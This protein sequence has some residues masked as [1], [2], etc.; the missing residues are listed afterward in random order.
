MKATSIVGH[1]FCRVRSHPQRSGFMMRRTQAIAIALEGLH[2]L[3]I[4]ENRRDLRHSRIHYGPKIVVTLSRR[5]RDECPANAILIVS[6]I[7]FD[8]TR[9]RG[10]IVEVGGRHFAYAADR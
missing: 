1:A 4:G 3:T 2:R 5:Y 8:A 9:M 6:G 10:R 7:K